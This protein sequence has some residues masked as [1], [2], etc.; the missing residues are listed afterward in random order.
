[1]SEDLVIHGFKLFQDFA[2][3]APGQ[4]NLVVGENNVGKTA[5]LEAL[6]LERAKQL[7]WAIVDVMEQRKESGV[8]MVQGFVRNWLSN[9]RDC[10][11]GSSYFELDY[12]FQWLRSSKSASKVGCTLEELRKSIDPVLVKTEDC[13]AIWQSGLDEAT[14]DSYWDELVLTGGNEEIAKSLQL[15]YPELRRIG[16]K[17]DG[18]TTRQPYFV[19][20]SGTDY[21]LGRLGQGMQRILG[22]VFGLHFCRGGRLLIDEFETGFHYSVM[23]KVW[24]WFC[25]TAESLN[26]EVF[27][28]THSLD[29]VNAF[30]ALAA[31]RKGVLKLYR[32]DRKFGPLRA[33]GYDEEQ[34]EVIAE[35]GVEVR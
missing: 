15:L 32:L 19:D 20:A 11:I 6:Y 8:P 13:L 3:R 9:Q 34:L 29:C 5:L 26:V 22:L 21:P 35:E 27:A 25:D 14:R 10:T 7:S 1:M 18:H 16:L 31:E 12:G 23:P 24:R 33:V 30:A 4:V 17:N 2:L 28:T